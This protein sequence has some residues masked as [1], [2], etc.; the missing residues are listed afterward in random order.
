[1]LSCATLHLRGNPIGLVS[2]GGRSLAF[3]W[4]SQGRTF[5]RESKGEY[6]WA[7]AEGSSGAYHWRT[8]GQIRVGDVIFSYVRKEIIAVAIARGEPTVSARPESYGDEKAWGTRGRRVTASYTRLPRPIVIASLDLQIK[9]ALSV[10]HGPLDRNFKGKQGYLFAI[11]PSVGER[12]LALSE[13][14]V[15]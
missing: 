11:P 13:I 7:P 14:G 2:G 12:L 9:T 1:M 8:V 4:V 5:Y 3:W 6:L 15:S 10:R